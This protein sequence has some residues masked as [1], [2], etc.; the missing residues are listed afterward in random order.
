ML[1][2]LFRPISDK[3]FMILSGRLLFAAKQLIFRALDIKFAP[4]KTT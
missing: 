3:F 2:A 1:Q 4:T